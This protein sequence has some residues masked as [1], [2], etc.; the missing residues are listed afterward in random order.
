MLIPYDQL[1]PETLH[2]LMADFVSRD[3]TDGGDDTPEAVKIE[4]V[5]RAL[6][7]GEAV[8]LYDVAYQQCILTLR[9]EVPAETLKAWT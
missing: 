8:F 6:K 1:Q 9:S 7:I 2:N 3:G 5:M 4:R